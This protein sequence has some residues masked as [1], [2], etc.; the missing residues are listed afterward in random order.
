MML[1]NRADVAFRNYL[2]IGLSLGYPSR[3]KWC[4]SVDWR[5][6]GEVEVEGKIKANC[7]LP[8]AVVCTLV[9]GLVS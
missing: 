8:E 1:F 7:R 5:G 3:L 6:I 4:G 9:L 2:R